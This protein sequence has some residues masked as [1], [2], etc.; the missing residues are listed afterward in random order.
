[1]ELENL[2]EKYSLMLKTEF[3]KIYA[4]ID[5]INKNK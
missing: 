2:K 3:A 4:K 1:M 5:A